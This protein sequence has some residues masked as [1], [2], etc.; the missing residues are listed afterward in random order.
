MPDTS[1]PSRRDLFRGSLNV[2]VLAI[3]A[4]G[5]QYGYAIQQQLLTAAGQPFKPGSL[6][7]ML[8]RMEE[9]GLVKATWDRNGARPRK[10]YELTAAGRAAFRKAAA[11]WQAYLARLQGAVLPAVRRVAAQK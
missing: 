4:D 5:R 3:L 6:Y 11:D 10:W 1:D 7:P 2:L 9:Q 8:H